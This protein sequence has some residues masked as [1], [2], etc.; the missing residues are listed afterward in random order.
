M[1]Y[2]TSIPFSNS[3][4]AGTANLDRL[5]YLVHCLISLRTGRYLVRLALLWHSPVVV[6]V[7]VGNDFT[8]ENNRL[9]F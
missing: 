5:F 4:S 3:L 8:D 1:F 7:L 9:F 2:D 6:Y